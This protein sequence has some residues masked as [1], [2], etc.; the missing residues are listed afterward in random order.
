QEK[1]K[2]KGAKGGNPLAAV[3]KKVK[4]AGADDATIEKVEALAKEYGPK[5][6]EASKGLG[7]AQKQMADARKAASADGKKGKDLQAAVDAAV[8]LTDE[9]KAA[10]AKSQELRKAFNAAVA[11]LLTPEQAKAA[12]VAAGRGDGKK[13]KKT[14]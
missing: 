12:G 9:Q 8:T 6:A 2:K 5:V 7:D 14:D 13:K 3:V 11:A 10:L 1:K 4:D